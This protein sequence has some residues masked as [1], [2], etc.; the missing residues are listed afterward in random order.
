MQAAA[1]QAHVQQTCGALG[2]IHFH[3]VLQ[4]H[5]VHCGRYGANPL[6]DAGA[7]RAQA[8]LANKTFGTGI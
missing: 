6:A 2:I 5:H 7:L 8:V 4:D 1:G 3:G